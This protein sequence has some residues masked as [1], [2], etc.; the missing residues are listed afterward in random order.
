MQTD[1]RVKFILDHLH[2]AAREVRPDKEAI[3][4]P[5]LDGDGR[6]LM[7]LAL[8]MFDRLLPMF[9]SAVIVEYQNQ[10]SK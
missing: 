7:N 6:D 9:V 3:P 5:E 2:A 8:N 10:V 1:A 4:F